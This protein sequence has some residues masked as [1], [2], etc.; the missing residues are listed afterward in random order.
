[1]NAGFSL[2]LCAILV[3]DDCFYLLGRRRVATSEPS[4][5]CL[6]LGMPSVFFPS[7]KVFLFLILPLVFLV[8]EFSQ[9]LR[10]NLQRTVVVILVGSDVQFRSRQMG[11]G[12]AWNF[13]VTLE[14]IFQPRGKGDERNPVQQRRAE[15]V[16]MSHSPVVV[17]GEERRN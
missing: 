8:V 13:R 17:R 7:I 6:S 4:A 12:A 1:M 10:E 16:Q 3:S 11:E 5:L 14:R 9:S 2:F 15:S